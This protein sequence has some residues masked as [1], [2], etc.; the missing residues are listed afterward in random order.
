[1]RDDLKERFL[2]GLYKDGEQKEFSISFFDKSN[3]EVIRIEA[4]KSAWDLLY[5]SNDIIKELSDISNGDLKAEDI[6]NVLTNLKIRDITE[7]MNNPKF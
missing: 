2:V 1:M 6:Y 4:E 3:R 5:S 7:D